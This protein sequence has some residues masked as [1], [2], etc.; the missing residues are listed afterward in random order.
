M[1][2]TTH[3]TS[4][5]QVP[6]HQSNAFPPFDTTTYSAQLFWLAVSF[7]LLLVV[8]WR[9]GVTR[10]GGNINARKS[11]I[12]GDLAEAER[13][14]QSAENASSE[15]EAALAA[16]RSRARTLAEDNR[17]RLLAEVERAKG[18]ADAQAQDNLVKA[19]ER[20]AAVREQSKAHVA[21][22]ARDA[23]IAIVARLT[24]TEVSTNE[25]DA[26]VQAA[27]Q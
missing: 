3:T 6:S 9:L 1:A 5:T 8:M 21:N 20:I 25:A 19:E 12:S 4:G 17:K 16:A 18:E 11:R 24:G 26:A 7:V 13:H 22:A 14:R 27:R 10:I 2:D 23:A 15:Y